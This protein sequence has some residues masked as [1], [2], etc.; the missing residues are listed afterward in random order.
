MEVLQLYSIL[1]EFNNNEQKHSEANALRVLFMKIEKGVELKIEDDGKGLDFSKKLN[2]L[3]SLGLKT[4]KE[5]ITSIHR[6]MKVT[7]EKGVGKSLIFIVY[8]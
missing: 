2:E 8:V 3:Q 1:Q 4:L 5:R 7:S 6:S